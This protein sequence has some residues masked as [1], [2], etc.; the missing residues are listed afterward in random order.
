MRNI[1]TMQIIHRVNHLFEQP[2]RLV[3]FVRAMLLNVFQHIAAVAKIQNHIDDVLRLKVLVHLH[4]VLVVCFAH[5]LHL[6]QQS[7]MAW[8]ALLHAFP[9]GA[10]NH[11]ERILVPRCAALHQLHRTKRASS[12]HFEDEIAALE[13]LARRIVLR[14]QLRLFR[15]SFELEEK[16]QF[17]ALSFLGLWHQH[18]LTTIVDQLSRLVNSFLTDPRAVGRSVVKENRVAAFWCVGHLFAHNLAM[19]VRDIGA[20]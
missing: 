3:S 4:D 1:Q 8:R 18:N 13:R 10:I 16:G 5:N 20:F 19:F 15:F 7:D 12:Q 9:R 17:L 11:F 14:R 2:T 6:V